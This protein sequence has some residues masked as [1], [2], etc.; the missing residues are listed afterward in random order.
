MAA[1]TERARA[2]AHC[3]QLNLQKRATTNPFRHMPEGGEYTMMGKAAFL[4]L[5]RAEGL[6]PPADFPS[7]G[8]DDLAWAW[9]DWW[10]E[11][12]S[13]WDDR[14]VERLWSVL[15][16]VYFYEVLEVPLER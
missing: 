2:D 1:F 5:I 3:Q 11:H 15:D 4:A 13:E 9:A 6:T 12:V 7:G 10:N 8:D 14:L 16:R